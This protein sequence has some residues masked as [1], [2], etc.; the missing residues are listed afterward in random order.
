VSPNPITDRIDHLAQAIAERVV[1]LVVNAIDLNALIARVDVNAIVDQVDIDAIVAKVDI[2]A[3]VQ[4][5]DI[6]EVVRHLDLDALMEHT[7][8]GPIIARSTSSVFSEIL[9]VIRAWGV[10]LDDFFARWTNRL[11]RRDPTTLPEGPALFV[12]TEP[13]Q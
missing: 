13:T 8:L 4:R 5:V 11:L 7:E 2:D 6:D 9:D 3:I 1:T 10:G 12:P